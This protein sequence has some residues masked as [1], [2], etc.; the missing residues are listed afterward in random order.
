MKF[1]RELKYVLREDKLEDFYDDLIMLEDW[2]P[3]VITS[4]LP[5]NVFFKLG[6]N[7]KNRKVYSDRILQHKLSNGQSGL[8]LDEVLE[9]EIHVFLEKYPKFEPLFLVRCR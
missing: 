1:N 3:F 4:N 8:S 2:I 7:V 9:N 6:K 5:Q